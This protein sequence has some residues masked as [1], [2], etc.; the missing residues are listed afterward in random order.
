VGIATESAWDQLEQ[1]AVNVDQA[2]VNFQRL[3]VEMVSR[4]WDISE[5]WHQ[6]QRKKH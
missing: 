1:P 5:T 6:K 4:N 3:Q 2:P